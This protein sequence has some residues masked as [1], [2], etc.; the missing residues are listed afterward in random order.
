LTVRANAL[1]Y[2]SLLAGIRGN[3]SA[4]IAYGREAGVLAESAGDKDKAALKWALSAQAY[5]ARGARDYQTEFTLAK[6]VRQLNREFGDTY[7][8]ALNLSLY[9]PTAMILGKY[10]EA[11]AMLDEALPLLRELGNP[12]RIAMALNYSG[13]LARCERNYGG[14]L[15]HYEKSVSI[16]REI[17]AMRD[18]ASILHNL[19]HACLHLGDVERA[20]ALFNESMSIQQAQHNT[21]GMTECLLGFA[22]LA[23]VRGIPAA[24]ARLFGTVMA[25]GGEHF[26]SGW[27]ATRMEYAHY[28]ALARAGLT[29]AEFQSEQAAGRA[30]SLEQA[31]EYAQSLPL[32]TASISDTG[33]PDMLTIR[34]REVAA[35]V[36]QGKSNGEIADELVVSKR[37]IE[38]HI[39]NILSK[40]GFTQ[41]AQIIRWAIEARPTKATE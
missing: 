24:A 23:V 8:L 1:T 14:A 22:A 4:V 3:A 2:A 25:I 20:H 37:T 40:L 7:Q 28:L 17:G 13:D 19:G 39:S 27:A 5:G 16:L 15:P 29:D 35:L 21:P 9:S 33:K 18:L 34:E 11:H 36:A 30:L 38:T 26:A 12:Y 31:V 6:R 32:K 10:D 41:R